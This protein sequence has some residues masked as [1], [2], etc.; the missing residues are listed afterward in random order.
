MELLTAQNIM[1]LIGLISILFSVFLYFKNPQIKSEKTDAL[2]EQRLQFERESTQ[3][4]FKDMQDG[5]TAATALAQNHIHSVDVKV[6]GLTALVSQ[7][8]KDIVRL[9]TIIDERIPRK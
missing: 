9:S 2:L 8:G 5:I 4:R 6:D 7:M 3:R 1:F